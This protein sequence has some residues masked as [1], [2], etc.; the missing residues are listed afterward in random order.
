MN[1]K[2]FSSLV[3]IPYSTVLSML[4][5]NIGGAAVDNVIKI[6]KELGVN[7]EALQDPAIEFK[8]PQFLTEKEIEHIK[9][10]RALDE[11]GQ[12]TV[13][14][15]LDIQYQIATTQKETSALSLVAEDIAPYKSYPKDVTDLAIEQEAEAYKQELLAEK[16]A[17]MSEA[18]ESSKGA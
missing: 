5:N 10:Y 16:K 17:K 2:E 4:N 12:R 11:R 9:K 3:K 8:N 15:T 18:S 14:S 13:D 1:I 7:V 6:C